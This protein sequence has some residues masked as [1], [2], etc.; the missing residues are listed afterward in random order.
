MTKVVFFDTDCIS[1]FLWTKTEY[2]LIHCFSHMIVPR[3]VYNEI[4]RV[5]FLKHRI[6]SLVSDG[7][8]KIEDILMNSDD[9][10]LYLHLTDYNSSNTLPLIGRGEAAAI[11]L[12]KKYKGILASN[13]F[14]DIKYYVTRYALNQIAT[15]DIIDR[16]VKEGVITVA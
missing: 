2:L 9:Y 3:Q 14:R 6:D 4:L 11:V 13:N 10:K 5:P 12:S 15:H 1:S 8:L 16:V 7:H